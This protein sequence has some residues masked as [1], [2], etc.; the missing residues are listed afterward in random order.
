MR[1]SDLKLL[2]N[3]HFFDG[4]DVYIY[5]T[6]DYG[7]RVARMLDKIGVIDY[8][9]CNSDRAREGTKWLGNRIVHPSNI[10]DKASSVAI[11]AVSPQNKQ[12]IK[13]ME[14]ELSALSDINTISFCALELFCAAFDLSREGDLERMLNHSIAES[15]ERTWDMRAA[16]GA[17]DADIL[18]FQPGKVASMSV[19]KGLLQFG[20]RA[21]FIHRFTRWA[22]LEKRR[23]YEEMLQGTMQGKKCITLVREPIARQISAFFQ[24]LYGRREG[25]RRLFQRRIADM[26]LQSA[27]RRYMLSTRDEFK[28][29]FE[30]EFL[31][32]ETWFETEFQPTTGIDVFRH[33][34]DVEKGYTII[35]ENGVE[36]LLMTMEHL[37][38]LEGVIGEFVGNSDFMLPKENVGAEK[39]YARLYQE[40]LDTFEIPREFYDHY[41]K[42]SPLM[43]HFYSQ[44]DIEKF[45]ARWRGHVKD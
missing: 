16:K 3:M 19:Y 24:V 18:V 11:V 17:L 9:F 40:T 36:V 25:S 2:D 34:F 35:R 43:K 27:L 13:E 10:P 42:D 23:E 29:W 41:Y 33:P 15:G 14:R 32:I 30:N 22:P 8:T 5:G 20:L 12:Y 7:F 21:V 28:T 38:S 37:S 4:K 6:G 45:A 1:Y 39:D 31:P 44:A 26:G